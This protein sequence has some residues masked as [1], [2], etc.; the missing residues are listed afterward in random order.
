MRVF[1]FK[2]VGIGAARSVSGFSAENPL[3]Q[4]RAGTAQSPAATCCRTARIKRE[5]CSELK[6]AGEKLKNLVNSNLVKNEIL[7]FYEKI[8]EGRTELQEL[9]LK[10][11]LPRRTGRL[12]A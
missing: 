5:I 3:M 6:N 8:E 1:C 9:R 12:E 7:E 10:R 4:A 11:K 2:A